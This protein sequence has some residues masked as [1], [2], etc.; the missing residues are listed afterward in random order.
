[1]A[2]ASAFVQNPWTIRTLPGFLLGAT[3]GRTTLN[4]E[5]LQLRVSS[6]P[7]RMVSLLWPKP[8]PAGG[9]PRQL[10]PGQLPWRAG[11]LPGTLGKLPG[12]A[13]QLPGTAGHCQELPASC[14]DL[15]ASCLP[16]LTYLPSRFAP[17][18]KG[19][20]WKVSPRRSPSSRS[21]RRARCCIIPTNR[22]CNHSPP[23]EQGV[24][25]IASL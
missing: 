15:P 16:G 22:V 19:L 21:R 2:V 3:A 11:K 24:P 7:I 12:A 13:R 1:M 14:Q 17:P 10:S 18:R 25:A 23:R 6:R 8:A 5:G 9:R 20:V 4:G